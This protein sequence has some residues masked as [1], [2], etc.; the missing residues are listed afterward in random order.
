MISLMTQAVSYRIAVVRILIHPFGVLD[1]NKK[2]N[3]IWH[4]QCPHKA[5][6]TQMLYK[7]HSKSKCYTK[8]GHFLYLYVV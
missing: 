8:L 6:S 1:K 5:S 4:P 3:I 7:Q 2:N